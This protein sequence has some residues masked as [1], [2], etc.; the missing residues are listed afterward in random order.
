[1]SKTDW[2]YQ[3]LREAVEDED[4]NIIATLKLNGKSKLE[5]LGWHYNED[6]LYSVKSGYWLSTHLPSALSIIPTFGDPYLKHRIWKTRM[7]SK[8]KHFVWKLMSR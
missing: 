3:K 6:G 4:F 5:L 2:D 8:I 7:P 1:M